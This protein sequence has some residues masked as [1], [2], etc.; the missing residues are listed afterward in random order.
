MV[1]AEHDTIIRLAALRV[2]LRGRQTT[3]GPQSHELYT[4]QIPPEGDWDCWILRGGRGSGKTEA[5]ARYVLDSLRNK[6][7]VRVGVGGPTIA[8]AR[9]V[10]AE[11]ETG[12]ITLAPSEFRYNRSLGEAWHR[13]GGYVKFLGS[14]EPD[15]WNGPQWHLLWADELALW[16]EES[17]HQAQFGVRLGPH[18]Q[19][20]VTTTPKSRPFVKAL[21]TQPGSVVTHATT[22]DN[23]ALAQRVRDRLEERYGGTRLGR[24]EL[25]GEDIEEI[26]GALWQSG[27]IANYRVD[28]EQA[29]KIGMSRIVVAVDPAVT[30]GDES[31]ETGIA[32]AGRGNDS[33]FYIFAGQG[34][35][36]S[37]QGWA[38]KAIDFYDTFQA[39]RVIAER[40]N[41]GEMVESTIRTVR[42][43]LPIKTIVASRGK[44][45]RAEPVAALYEQGK[46]HHVGLFQELEDQMTSFPVANEHDDLVDALVYAIT[47]LMGGGAPNVH[48]L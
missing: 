32:V 24:Q 29:D 12:L 11:G 33:Q 36:L 23:P 4:H 26:E 28:R 45:L 21:Y 7:R 14:E 41:G 1:V 47:E 6:G 8:S 48:F 42:K 27:W 46:V 22:Y 30:H 18:P 5:G 17:W 13:N 3:N 31:D 20:V 43:T 39:D 2:K 15:R 38:Q 44:T 34:Y 9:D 10:C 37:P 40:N 25:M 16:N 19:T 35:R